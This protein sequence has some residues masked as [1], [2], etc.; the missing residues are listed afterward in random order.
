MIPKGKGSHKMTKKKPLPLSVKTKIAKIEARL[1]RLEQR[2][3]KLENTLS[4]IDLKLVD[5]DEKIGDLLRPYVPHVGPK[6]F[7]RR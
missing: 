7:H 4:E 3:D 5:E 2:R 1:K 6:K